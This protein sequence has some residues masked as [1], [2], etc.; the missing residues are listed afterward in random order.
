MRKLTILFP[1]V[2]IFSGVSYAD[3]IWEKG[4]QKTDKLI[5]I[6]PDEQGYY[7]VGLYIPGTLEQPDKVTINGGTKVK[8]GEVHV[9]N[10][11][12]GYGILTVE[13]NGTELDIREARINV[14]G[15][16]SQGELYVKDGAKLTQSNAV[17]DDNYFG[18]HG[19]TA[20]I[21][22]EGKNSEI[23]FNLGKHSIRTSNSKVSLEN[24]GK[25]T[26]NDNYD[27]NSN[28]VYLPNV[29]NNGSLISQRPLII[30][31]LEIGNSE[32]T[33]SGSFQF[34]KGLRVSK[35]VINKLKDPETTL[36]INRCNKCTIE[37]NAD[38]SLTLLKNTNNPSRST[39]IINPSLLSITK[40]KIDIKDQ[41]TFN[42]F[43]VET[44]N[45]AREAT[46][47]LSDLS[48][49]NTEDVKANS[50]THLGT[51]DLA[52][53]SRNPKFTKFIVNNYQ[54]GGELIV[55]S[56]WNQDSQ[57]SHNDSLHIKGDI[58]PNAITTVKTKN[59]IFGDI[60]RTTEDQFSPVVV[61]VDMEHEGNLFVGSSATQNAGEA[62]LAKKE[63]NYYWTLKA[64]LPDPTP[65]PSEITPSELNINPN[66]IPNNSEVIPNKPEVV[67]QPRQ[68]QYIDIISPSVV[69]YLQLPFVNRQMGLEQL[70]KLHERIG[71]ERYLNLKQ[72]TADHKQV[73][74]RLNYSADDFQGINR[75]G[76]KVRS[77]FIQLGKPLFFELKEDK[78]KEH[79]GIIF[80]YG[81]AKSY[82]F[83]KYRAENG[84]VV[85]D[86][87]TGIA[88][89]DMFSLGSYYTYYAKNGFYI[90][91]TGQLSWLKNNYNSKG[92]QA[93]QD[94]YGLG[95][96][97]EIG[98]HIPLKHSELFF[99]PQ[100]QLSYQS[101]WLGGF[102]DGTKQVKKEQQ[103]SL[104]GRL[105]FR[106]GF[107]SNL[108]NTNKTQLYLAAHLLQTLKGKESK[109][110][111]GSDVVRESFGN[112]SAEFSIGGQYSIT[113]NLRLY[114]NLRH[115]IGIGDKNHVY[116]SSPISRKSYQGH[117]GLHYTW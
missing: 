30:R 67:P 35:L 7:S 81:W 111:V 12:T 103:D 72:A 40:G 101:I 115:I 75:F 43:K 1:V 69:G 66:I 104:V 61:T 23:I 107:G 87:F 90:D 22:V 11:A 71:E 64:K 100:A 88:K 106:L 20:K 10:H 117:L 2:A 34:D 108:L 112:L 82:F 9:G 32:K 51:L 39:N 70:G 86:K 60:I 96:S 109:I 42:T 3:V 95:A 68:P 94:G 31:N 54:G 85:A 50:F 25:I 77:G 19:G 26:I 18:Y 92:M 13:G 105:G 37:Y 46:F 36:P 41:E 80:T 38:E 59:G 45:L 27:N 15:S 56:V 113:D 84:V 73:W 110:S 16:G 4:E 5:G 76:V 57:A 44:L 17:H 28:E 65:E 52:D 78:A 49:S 47:S 8:T 33:Q 24:G 6:Q 97:I 99:E 93:K 29:V 74:A 91:T 89:T 14:G 102:N 21:V 116:H 62:Q 55:D 114:V 58:N 63:G 48:S 98:K 83:D 79:L 53:G